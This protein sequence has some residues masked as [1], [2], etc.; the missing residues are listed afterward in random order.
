M[1]SKCLFIV[2]EGIDGTGKTSV[3]K[4]LSEKLGA[5]NY[6]TPSGRWQKYR[7]VVEDRHPFIRFIYYLLSTVCSSLEISKLLRRNSVVCDRYIHS[8]WCHHIVYGCRFLKSIPVSRLP[9]K[10][11]DLIYYLTVTSSEREK[12]INMRKGNNLKDKDSESLLKVHKY[13]SRIKDMRRVDTTHRDV[14][15]VVDLIFRDAASF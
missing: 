1:L 15:E 11:P 12:R 6:K 4:S 14:T 10:K 7:S 3:C 13:F 9:V 5:V 2:I 8:T